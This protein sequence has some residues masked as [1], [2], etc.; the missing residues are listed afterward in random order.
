MHNTRLTSHRV[1]FIGH[2][3]GKSC[4]LKSPNFF[5]VELTR[6]LL[7]EGFDKLIVS[8]DGMDVQYCSFCDT[9]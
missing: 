5:D 3:N 2:R 1:T 4:I 6:A 9:I 8:C 7:V